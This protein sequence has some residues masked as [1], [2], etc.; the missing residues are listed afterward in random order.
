MSYRHIYTPDALV[1]FK[2][3]VSWYEV[4]SKRAAENFVI[5]VRRK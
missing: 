3:A 5:A 4:R 1:E 2:G